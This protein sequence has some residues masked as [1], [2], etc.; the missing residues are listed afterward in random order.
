MVDA[1]A[2]LLGIEWIEGMSVN[3]VLLGGVVEDD[4]KQETV[5]ESSGVQDPLSDFG[6]SSGMHDMPDDYL[7][8]GRRL[9]D[10]LMLLIG[11]EIG[12]MHMAD[13]IHGDLTTSNMMLRHPS[14]FKTANS[15]LP[16][17]LVRHQCQ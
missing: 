1:S 4:G 8:P 3:S 16:T 12:K 15:N 7:Y 9:S 10:T 6:I 13:I 2:G 17:E 5:S 14:S 11:T